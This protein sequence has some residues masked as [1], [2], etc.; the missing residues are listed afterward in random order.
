MFLL[1]SL[2]LDFPS[3]VYC[4]LELEINF[5]FPSSP[6]SRTTLVG[7]RSP[8]LTNHCL[9]P[10]P[11]CK[12]VPPSGYYTYNH[13]HSLCFCEGQPSS[14]FSKNVPLLNLFRKYFGQCI[15]RGVGEKLPITYFINVI[16]T[17]SF[18]NLIITTCHRLQSY[19][20]GFVGGHPPCKATGEPPFSDPSSSFS[21]R[22]D[23]RV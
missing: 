17:Y 13:K 11:P 6:K 23:Q 20:L 19:R 15:V 3:L 2:F 16:I 18:T 22:Q 7:N 10:P 1:G 5:F 21:N 8:T 9:S 14:L 12:F 4:D